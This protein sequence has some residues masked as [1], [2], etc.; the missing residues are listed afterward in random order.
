MSVATLPSEPIGS[1]GRLSGVQG[2]AEIGFALKQGA[3]RLNHLYQHDPLRVMFPTPPAGEPPCAV[4]VTT[5]GGMVGGDRLDISVTAGPKTTA[6]AMAQAAEKVYR[7]AG[8][9]S[10]INVRLSVGKNSWLEWL[11]QETILF[12]GARLC[13][14]TVIDLEPDARI[15]AGEILVFGRIASG[16]RLSQGLV[17]EAWELRRDGRLAWADALHLESPMDDIFANPACFD[18]ATAM[19]TAVYADDDAAQYLEQARTL[20]GEGADN[21]RCAATVAKMNW[22][23]CNS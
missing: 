2:A 5:S 18:G 14:R 10:S 23:R 6:M 11:P 4:L 17:R 16:E 22:M 3:T 12:D 13:R 20:L 7:S 21:L 15:L 9:D 19:A 8:E 1:A